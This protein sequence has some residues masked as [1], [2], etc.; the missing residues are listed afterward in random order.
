MKNQ[1]KDLDIDLPHL[2]GR[3][4]LKLLFLT[5]FSAILS[6]PIQQQNNKNGGYQPFT[7][8]HEYEMNNNVHR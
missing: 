4:L 8:N 3:F 5:F 6:M 2:I 7:N 1:I